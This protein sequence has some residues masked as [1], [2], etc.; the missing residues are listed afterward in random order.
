MLFFCLASVG[1]WEFTKVRPK[2]IRIDIECPECGRNLIFW[3]YS[4]PSDLATQNPRDLIIVVHGFKST[5]VGT[6]AATR[7][8]YQ[9]LAESDDVVVVHAQSEESSGNWFIGDIGSSPNVDGQNID[10]H[11]YFD[12]LWEKVATLYPSLDRI[13]LVGMSRGAMASYAIACAQRLPVVSLTVFTMP[14][15]EMALIDCKEVSGVDFTLVNGT[16]DNLV[17][18]YGGTI[19]V[20]WL[21][22]ARDRQ[23]GQV[24]ETDETLSRWRDL[25]GCDR[26]SVARHE[27]NEVRDGTTVVTRHWS[28]CD[29][30]GVTHIRI[31]GGGHRWDNERWN[32]FAWSVLGIT[33]RETIEVIPF[34][35]ELFDH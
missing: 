25:N 27:R 34:T 29:T 33:T 17:P 2:G 21:A 8:R 16:R 19:D 28:D 22:F 23:F 32:P 35:H 20:P 18:F 4:G 15:P 14:M 1:L 13:H 31:V 7:G 9:D 26:Y 12:Q 5:A 24:A 6:I 3:H 11:A 30:G 10:D